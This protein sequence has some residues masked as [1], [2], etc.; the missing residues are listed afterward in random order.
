M[1]KYIL[2]P[3]ICFMTF[4]F[5]P[6]EIK[7][8]A[9]PTPVIVVVDSAALKAEL[10]NRLAVIRATDKQ[11]MNFREKRALNKEERAINKSLHDNYGGVYLSVGALLLI[12]LILIILF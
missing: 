5:A 7:A 10:Q 12:I 6:N 8:S 4:A 2:V 3:F 9:G 1:K 11:P